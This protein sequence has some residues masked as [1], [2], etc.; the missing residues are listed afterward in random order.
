MIISMFGLT[1]LEALALILL[2]FSLI[3]LIR[4]PFTVFKLH[5]SNKKKLAIWQNAY[6]S[7]YHQIPSHEDAN[8]AIKDGTLHVHRLRDYLFGSP[9]RWGKLILA[10]LL[11]AV[12]SVATSYN[13]LSTLFFGSAKLGMQSALTQYA[14]LTPVIAILIVLLLVGIYL[15]GTL[16]KKHYKID[17]G[18]KMQRFMLPLLVFFIGVGLTAPTVD[19]EFN[20]IFQNRQKLLSTQEHLFTNHS[21]FA[22]YDAKTNICVYQYSD[23][24][25]KQFT[26]GEKHVTSAT[27]QYDDRNSATQNMSTSFDAYITGDNAQYFASDDLG[28]RKNIMQYEFPTVYLEGDGYNGG[29][30]DEELTPSGKYSYRIQTGDEDMTFSNLHQVGHKTYATMKVDKI[31]YHV[32]VKHSNSIR[33]LSNE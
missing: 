8:A 33:G 30:I 26:D 12:V 2:A 20:R 22:V 31:K 28:E 29:T 14:N 23:V 19:M 32:Y 4:L 18:T 11:G 16:P 10:F 5:K 27:R 6:A 15:F 21:I 1:L 9:V 24:N 13:N 25:V 7:V 3:E 17:H